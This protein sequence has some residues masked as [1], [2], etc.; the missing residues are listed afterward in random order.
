M[1]TATVLSISTYNYIQHRILRLSRNST[2]LRSF[3]LAL[4]KSFKELMVLLLIFGAAVI[5]FAYLAYVCEKEEE[6]TSYR[7][8][9]SSFWWAT[10]TLTTVR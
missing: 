10:I 2:S 5:T 4:S 9:F 6:E 1:G 7:H 8:M 3:G